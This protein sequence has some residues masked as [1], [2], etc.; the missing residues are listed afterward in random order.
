MLFVCLFLFQFQSQ[1]KASDP[2][3]S[4]VVWV[5]A[6]GTLLFG[7]LLEY[8]VLRQDRTSVVL[9]VAEFPVSL[10][11]PFSRPP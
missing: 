5:F 2:S 6:S 1:V 9:V 10:L 3:F 7:V 8:R 11:D 4:H